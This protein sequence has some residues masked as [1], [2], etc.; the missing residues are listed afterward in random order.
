M[1]LPLDGVRVLEVATHV[2]AP[3]AGAVLAEWGADVVKVEAPDGGDPYRGLV[4]AGLHPLHEGVDPYFQSA[5]RGKASVGIDLTHPD[6]RALLSR[7][8]AGADVFVTNLRA[9]ARGR[10]RLE[11]DDI[12]A[13]NP[14]AVYVRATAFGACGPDAGRGG[15]DASAYWARSGM[16]HA[17][18]P[19]D[20][21]WPTPARPAFG[22]VVGALAI[23]GAVSTAL[24][25]R[26]TTGEA[27]V[28]DASL[29]AAGMWQLQPDIVSATLD[30]G[31]PER[32]PPDRA[33]ARNPLMLTYRTADGRFLALA[34]L[35]ADRHWPDLCR[36]LGHPE[37]ATD[38]RFADMEARRR[39]AAACVAWLDEVF[40]GRDLDE[41][42]RVLAGFAGEWA[43]VQT[44]GELHDDPQV[45]ANGY[46][47]D[48]DMGG[49]VSLP[50]VASP[51]QFDEQPGRPT[52]APEHG[53]HT[54][55]VLLG[56]GL[57]WDEITAL[58]DRGAIL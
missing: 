30:G 49:G 34:M 18:T 41:W 53:E 22:D 1:P 54:E 57:S 48:V 2:F 37:A 13:D 32:R 7:L 39:N 27:S 16:Q 58:K 25:R 19:P 5:N 42:R 21:A 17:L 55:A 11:V 46:L 52:R 56:L 3:L 9:G 4:T 29:L 10:L 38:P 12:R 40:A 20:A 6:G 51:V 31:D 43:P 44:P 15:Y 45:V 14:S 8:V 50:L 33:T 47:P 24:Y 36:V 23:A 28:I 35:A 26:A